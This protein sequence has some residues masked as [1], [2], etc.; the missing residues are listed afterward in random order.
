MGRHRGSRGF[1]GFHPPGGHGGDGGFGH[2][3]RIRGR[4]IGSD[5]LQLLLLLLLEERPRHGYELIKAIEQRSSGFYSPSPGMIYPALTYLEELGHATVSSEAG[6]KLYQLADAGRV[7]LNLHRAAAEMVLQQLERFG[8][9][10]AG[11]PEPAEPRGPT[12][13]H[14]APRKALSLGVNTDPVLARLRHEA[15]QNRPLDGGP[16]RSGNN[17]P[18]QYAEYGFS[19]SQEQGELIYLLCRQMRARRVIDFATSVGVSAIYF[20]AAMRDNQDGLVIGSEIVPQKVR[21]AEQ[22]LR[23]AGVDFWVNIREGDAR[24]TLQGLG[25]PFDFAL[26]DGWPGDGP[27]SLAREVVEL[28]APNIRRGGMLMNDN[29]EPDYL[30]Y[31][32]DPRNGF[33]SITLPMKGG[34]E[35]SL[36]R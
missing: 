7:H 16:H 6:R 1:Q 3:G 13:R 32:R 18:F 8:R 33:I 24:E 11:A 25:E 31:V 9:S 15:E 30:E 29:G 14:H 35:L 2:H 23:Q 17:D 34:T 10:L 19:I 5:D 26:I 20:G 22:N 21:V 12:A 28:V 36:K 27:R 4:K